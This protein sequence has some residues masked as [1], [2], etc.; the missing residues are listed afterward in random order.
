MTRRLT[1]VIVGMVAGALLLAG[2]GTLV[3]TQL[4]A[5]QEARRDLEQQAVDVAISLQ[6]TR[7]PAVTQALRRALR[8]QGAAV[9]AF[10]AGDIRT[11]ALPAGVSDD[12]IDLEAL[13]A[14]RVISGSHGNL[15]FAAAR[16]SSVRPGDR[17]V[18]LTRKAD[19]GLR[20][21][22]RWFAVAAFITLAGA[23]VV[24][25]VLGSRLTRPLRD[26]QAATRRIAAGDLSARLPEPRGDDELAT[27]TRSINTMAET[28]E[29]SRGLER[30]FL[31]AVSH[32]LRTPL[33]S[34]R[35]FAEAIADGKAPDDA[36]AAAVITA[37]S[38]RLERLVGDL[39]ELAKL[40]ARR[41]SLD[42]RATDVAEVVTE[43]AE[44]FR[45]AADDA[46]VQ[47]DVT[48]NGQRGLVATADPDRLAQIVANL[49]ENALK[50]ASETIIVGAS[51]DDGA[52]VV[53]VADD[54]PGIP[55]DDLPHVFE[56]FFTSTRT[57]ARRVGSGL[58]LS[59]VR[60]LVDA[61]G[62]TVRAEPTDGRG[63]RIVVAL[64]PWARAGGTG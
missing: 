1:I 28:L 52:V 6:G 60:E 61:M 24:A 9:V 44:G 63:A 48:T 38:R 34:I 35:G 31:L 42:V 23:V 2:V 22:A 41:F 26:A 45:P 15:A 46:N 7:R 29:R 17:I 20:S 53:W 3:L 64:K 25:S 19:S 14:G 57:P 5:R 47:L 50:F 4:G 40:D 21:G 58:G 12:D 36:Q 10:G 32:D 49:V 16:V 13:R 43:T 39:L 54:G 59:I 56:R 62:A 51:R 30:Q 37:E 18:I 11:A 27:L 8:L 33:T 55:A